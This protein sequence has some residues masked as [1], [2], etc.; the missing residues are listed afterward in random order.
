[1]DYRDMVESLNR[2]EQ[3]A[4][5]QPG[6]YD[7]CRKIDWEADRILEEMDR[8]FT[9]AIASPKQVAAMHSVM[10]HR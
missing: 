3:Q 9:V 6:Y 4:R 7:G 2:N 1:M 8:N 10:R 5:M